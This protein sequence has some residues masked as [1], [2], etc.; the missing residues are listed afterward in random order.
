[1]RKIIQDQQILRNVKEMTFCY[2]CG[3]PIKNTDNT[4]YDHIPP[5]SIFLKSDRNPPLKLKTHYSCNHDQSDDD[6]F[7]GQLVGLLHG[8][9]EPEK[10]SKLNIEIARTDT[11]NNTGIL[12]SSDIKP[13]VKRWVQGFHAALYKSYLSQTSLKATILPFP[14][15]VDSEEGPN[16]LELLDMAFSISDTLIRCVRENQFDSII[17]SNGKMKYICTWSK[18]PNGDW[19]CLYA[20]DLYNWSTLGDIHNTSQR[21]CVGMYQM[22]ANFIPTDASIYLVPEDPVDFNITPDPF[23]YI[24]DTELGIVDKVNNITQIK[25]EL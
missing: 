22:E 16:I 5:Q 7:I 21:G 4:N 8:H 2:F 19:V 10:Y 6:E 18:L 11:H 25:D 12:R 14:E 3:Q 9:T 24:T 13:I 23:L 15:G 17:T 1:M 20:L